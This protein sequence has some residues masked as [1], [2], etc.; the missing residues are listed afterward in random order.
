MQLEDHAER[1]ALSW[2]NE[3]KECM[4]VDKDEKQQLYYPCLKFFETRL[5][6]FKKFK[7]GFF[8]WEGGQGLK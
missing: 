8:V 5:Y 6:E 4:I 1:T 2:N 3:Y 7:L